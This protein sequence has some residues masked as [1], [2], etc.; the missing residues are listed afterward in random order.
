[1]ESGLGGG[2]PSFNA[3]L[4]TNKIES[5][6]G[7]TLPLGKSVSIRGKNCPTVKWRPSQDCDF[8]CAAGNEMRGESGSKGVQLRRYLPFPSRIPT[9]P[10]P[11]PPC[12]HSLIP[13]RLKPA[14]SGYRP[15]PHQASHFDRAPAAAGGR[16]PPAVLA[17][18]EF[19][20]ATAGYAGPGPAAGRCSAA[21][22]IGWL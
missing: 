18:R 6:I 16:W 22:Q 4:G 20:P 8:Q 1:M 11:V 12:C 9:G 7:I 3:T 5:G 2:L 10:A 13:N 17:R 21:C 15:Q 14:C 19:Q